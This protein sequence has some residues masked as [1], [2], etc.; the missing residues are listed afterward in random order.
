MKTSLAKLFRKDKKTHERLA[1]LEEI[2]ESGT[3]EQYIELLL[4]WHPRMNSSGY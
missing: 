4:T 1:A 2:L 3:E